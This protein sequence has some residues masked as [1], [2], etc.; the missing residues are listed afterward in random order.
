MGWLVSSTKRP[1]E[2]T[3]HMDRLELQLPYKLL[4]NIP[5]YAFLYLNLNPRGVYQLSKTFGP[6]HKM[7][8]QYITLTQSRI[9][10]VSLVGAI[11]VIF[12][13][14]FSLRFTSVREMKYTSQHCCDKTMDG[15]M[16]L[17]REC[18]FPNCS[19]S[20]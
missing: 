1:V 8:T 11:S 20:W 15:K 4:K 16:A 9:Q 7:L 12:G 13:S 19:K 6:Y 2:T 14:Q 18:Y 10:P 17:Y 3:W 5:F